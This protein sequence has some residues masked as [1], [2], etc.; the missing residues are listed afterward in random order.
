MPQLTGLGPLFLF[1]IDDISRGTPIPIRLFVQDYIIF[2]EITS[3]SDH[4]GIDSA[5][6]RMERM[7]E[8]AQLLP[9]TTVSGAV[10]GY[11]ATTRLVPVLRF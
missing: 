4:L 5:L 8:D 3:N 6:P 2:K 7:D 9:K 1:F 10:A 11:L